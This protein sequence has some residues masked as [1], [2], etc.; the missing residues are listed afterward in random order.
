MTIIEKNGLKINSKLFNFVNNEIIPGTN[1]K[2]EQFW[3][4]FG[5]IVHELAPIN[6]KL[7][8]KREDIQKKIDEWHKKNKGK[9]FSKKEYSNFLKSISYIV[10]EKDNFNIETENVDEEI[11]KIA[12][13]QL[14]VPV[15][16]ARYALNAANARWG[17]LYDALY[18]TDV[19][20]G[21]K[22]KSF[23]EQ[24]A[25]T[26]IAYVRKFLNETVPLKNGS[27]NEITDIKVKDNDIVF[28]IDK[29]E[30]FLK[31]KDQFIGYNVE[32]DKLSSILLKN[33]NLHIDILIDPNHFIG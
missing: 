32:K 20:P 29:K 6:N 11:A 19:I 23:D 28:L 14:V 15:D 33:N 1:I 9:E 31:N 16:N 4:S 8:K 13:S 22:G 25:R 5:K 24:R 7:I 26:V 21:Y 27:W 10:E 12:G 17:S 3:T 2:S 18:G 30:I